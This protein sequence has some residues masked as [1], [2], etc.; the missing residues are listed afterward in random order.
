MVDGGG[1]CEGRA[2]QAL[3]AL[4][5]KEKRISLC[6]TE[7]ITCHEKIMARLEALIYLLTTRVS[8]IDVDG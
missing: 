5:N 7:I 8:K 4:T 2:A 3:L 6:H 1:G